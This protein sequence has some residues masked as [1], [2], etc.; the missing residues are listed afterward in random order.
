MSSQF[1]VD[2]GEYTLTGQAV[3]FV[4]QG[5]LGTEVGSYSHTG[6]DVSL[7]MTS[8]FDVD[9]GSYGYTGQDASLEFTRINK[10]Y[11][12]VG[13]YYSSGPHARLTKN[14]VPGICEIYSFKRDAKL[15][16]V[17]GGNRYNIDISDVTFSQTFVEQSIPVKTVQKQQ[18]FEA[19]VI[20]KA[21]PANFS[22]TIPAIR[23]DDLKI[24]IDRALDYQDFELY[25]DTTGEVFKLE[26]C[27][28][29]NATF[30]IEKLRPLSVVI[31]GEASKLTLPESLSGTPIA[32]D[33]SRTYNKV[34]AVTALLGLS[35]ITK[36]LT[37]IQIQL[38]N[39]INWNP[40]VTL[41]GVCEANQEQELMYPTNYVITNRELSGS[42][43][44][45]ITDINNVDIQ[46]WGLNTSLNIK[47]GQTVSSTVYGFEF[48]MADCF[49][50][51]RLG[52]GEIFTQTY[53]WRLTENPA[54]LSDLITYVVL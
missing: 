47:V 21:N 39:N 34:G 20:N 26:T 54:N 42:I 8:Q 51:N 53:D 11:T 49:F 36:N 43:T 32:R 3:T 12:S 37:S 38:S 40:Y 18:M 17:F 13:S 10:L 27:I 5:N 25:I 50:K 31:S 29:T 2:A 9:A 24:V 6:Q 22:F 16:I 1:D 4:T 35:D 44:T 33:S 23:E 48:D 41:Q 14:K 7:K 46:T 28:I 45:Y 52:T 30:V 19:A 15:Y